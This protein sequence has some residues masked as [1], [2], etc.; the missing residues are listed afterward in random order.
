MKLLRHVCPREICLSCELGFLFFML[1]KQK[2]QTCQVSSGPDIA[3]TCPCNIQRFF[4]EVKIENFIRKKNDIF[5]IFAQ[6][7]DYGYS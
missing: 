3:K 4:S 5:L 2:G 7:I 1:D 6:N